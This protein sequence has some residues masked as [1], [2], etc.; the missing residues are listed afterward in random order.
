MDDCDDAVDLS[1]VLNGH[2]VSNGE[3]VRLHHKKRKCRVKVGL[4]SD[5]AVKF[6]CNVFALTVTATDDCGNEG[7]EA[8]E[9]VF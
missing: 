6:E 2:P 3:I 1:A 9:H 7:M 5:S 8:A 4:R